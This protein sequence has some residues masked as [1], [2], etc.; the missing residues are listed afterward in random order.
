VVALIIDILSGDL[1]HS[2]QDPHILEPDRILH[3]NLALLHKQSE[4]LN[5]DLLS[6]GLDDRFERSILG[7]LGQNWSNK[8][9]PSTDTMCNIMDSN[10]LDTSL[11]S[12]REIAAISLLITLE[13]INCSTLDINKIIT[14]ANLQASVEDVSNEGDN[15]I[16]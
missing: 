6:N 3:I 16:P 8:S 5:E 13:I 1:S 15:I 4:P 12:M 10:S 11:L 9:Q 2:Y 14:Q 7:D